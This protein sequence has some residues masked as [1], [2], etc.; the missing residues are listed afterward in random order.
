[1]TSNVFDKEV[2][3]ELRFDEEI[4]TKANKPYEIMFG[5][6]KGQNAFEY[7]NEDD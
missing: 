5:K 6:V 7:T 4:P 3:K 2:V 1:M